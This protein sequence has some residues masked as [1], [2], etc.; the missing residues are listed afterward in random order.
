MPTARVQPVG[1]GVGQLQ[2]PEDVPGYAPV[3]GAAAVSAPGIVYVRQNPPVQGT[4]VP[5]QQVH[6]PTPE[7]QRVAAAYEAEQR[8]IAAPTDLSDGFGAT[9][10]FSSASSSIEPGAPSYPLAS[11]VRSISSNRVDR[12][13]SDHR[14]PAATTPQETFVQNARTAQNDDYLKSTRTPPVSQYEIKACWE[15]P[16]VMEQGLNSDLPGEVKALVRLNVCDTATGRYVLIPQDARLV[17]EYNSQLGYGQ[18]GVQVIWNRVIYPD[19]SSLDLSGML[20]QDAHGFSGFRDRVDHHYKRLVGFA[21]LTSLFAAASNVAQNQNRS[22]LTY[23]SPGEVAGSAVGQQVSDLGAQITRK[24]LNVQPTIKIPV[25][26]RFNVRVNR[27]VILESP[28]N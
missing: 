2:A 4:A 8:A 14:S 1:S 16:A 28:Y 5:V 19:S 6:Q 26:Y 20:G 25:G 15:I 21:V 7:E 11:G 10:G 22:V 3:P 27:D 24:N 23:P 9:N 13:S 12:P 18:D 17:G